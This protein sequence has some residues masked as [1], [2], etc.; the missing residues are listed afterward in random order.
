M[1]IFDKI[2]QVVFWL[3]EVLFRR[4]PAGNTKIFIKNFNYIAIGFGLSAI[5]G[6]ITQILMGRFLG[7]EGYGKYG[8]VQSLSLFLYIPMSLGIG[9]AMVKY[10]AEEDDIKRQTAII[11]T[12]LLICAVL[13]VVS[14]FVLFVFSAQISKIFGVTSSLMLYA[15]FFALF[16][17]MH[18]FGTEALR[19]LHK[20]KELSIFQAFDGFLMLVLILFFIL[21]KN[22]SFEISV[23]VAFITYFAIFLSIIFY[24]RK[25]LSF[26]AD[27][28]W[29]R[30][31]IKYGAFATV[32]AAAYVFLLNFN[33]ILVNKYLTIDDVGIYNAYYFASTGILS[34][35]LGMFVTVFFPM[36]SRHKDKKSILKKIDEF[37]PYLFLIGVPFFF[38]IEFII[39]KLYGN[40]YPIDV[41]LMTEF[42]V[43]GILIVCYNLYDYLF[44]SH[45]ILGIKLVAQSGIVMV[46]FNVI[47]GF[48]L[49]PLFGLHGAIISLGASYLLGISVYG[50]LRKKI[51]Y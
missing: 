42:V 37:M 14:F 34:V 3:Y 29:L 6:F 17:N 36:A 35:L 41:Y 40:K 12:S 20:M 45:G 27:T 24:L 49:I 13:S 16:Y 47:L 10:N 32:G 19:G 11:S 30:K 2:E 44:A 18:V 23:Y 26:L 28:V 21:T 22:F 25:Y 7:P 4:E 33:K 43:T 9:T 51:I 48:Y 50:F 38:I 15:I 1:K 46:L 5:F 8:L 39:L 31:I